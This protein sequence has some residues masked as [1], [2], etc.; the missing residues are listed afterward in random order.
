M[1]STRE[2]YWNVGREGLGDMYLLA[3]A[4]AGFIFL[5]MYRFWPRLVGN[6]KPVVRTDH[7]RARLA[8][9]ARNVLFQSKTIKTGGVGGLAHAF[10]F[11]GFCILT[12]GTTLVFIQDDFTDRLF[13]FKFLTGGFYLLF[14]LALDLGGLFAMLAIL[15][16]SIRR[17]IGLPEGY[18]TGFGDMLI[19][20]LLFL[21]L[22]TGFMVEGARIAF[23][24][25]RSNIELA[26]W[27]PVGLFFAGMFDATWFHGVLPSE[28]PAIHK[29]LWWIHLYI[30]MAFL[31]VIG[32]TRLRHVI[33]IPANF[34]YVDMEQNGKLVTLDLEDE[35]AQQFGAAKVGDLLWKDL[36]DSG[37]CVTCL[38]CQDHCP[39]HFTHKPLDPMQMVKDI[40]GS[41]SN[42]A[43][44][45]LTELMSEE[46]VWSCLTC[47]LCQQ[48]CP[49]QVE[50][51]PKIIDIRRNLV[52]MEGKFPGDEVVRAMESIEISGNP[53]GYAPSL[54]GD[55]A[56]KLELSTEN[57]D[58]LYFTGCYASYDRRNMKVARS[59]VSV[60]QK[61]GV[62]VGIMGKKEKC[63]GEP[64]RKIGNEYLYQNLA[65]ENIEAIHATGAKKILT[66]CPHC[67]FTLD[68][69][70][71]DLGLDPAVEVEHHTTFLAALSDKF[72]SGND[73]INVTYHDSCYMGRYS[74]VFDQPRALLASLGARVLEME[75]N[76][77]L[78]FCC[79][80]GGGRILAEEKLGIRVNNT[81]GLM[82]L[83]T[84]A[85]VLVSNCPFCMAML[86]DGVATP[87][88]VKKIRCMDLAE[89]LDE[90]I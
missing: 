72:N 24:E 64:A 17:F 36:F 2:I 30:C 28:L 4:T 67:Y 44:T 65:K 32:W 83:E 23:T 61:L 87:K 58:V 3:L 60:L 29:A 78:S 33:M 14:S 66:T 52:L 49:A 74:G 79:G 15:F 71:R 20:I 81:R 38:R 85:E 1:E 51:V 47:R 21:A 16:L 70:Y 63:C 13:G 41:L 89:F 8:F 6:G 25:Y 22:F 39:A 40:G 42:G 50:H 27:S 37:A 84:E 69:E 12:I 35:N 46:A 76:R 56:E 34:L 5:G 82:A 45:P 57:M 90:R 11:W 26:Y 18:D 7:I 9:M 43:D 48:V 59:F 31:G 19:H 10:L 75:K 68:K 86:E 88:P 73:P 77:E 53:L 55:W 80:G 62:K 54:R